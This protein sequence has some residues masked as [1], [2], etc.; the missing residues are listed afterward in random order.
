GNQRADVFEL[1]QRQ[2]LVPAPAPLFLQRKDLPI[3]RIALHEGR[4]GVSI[5]RRHRRVPEPDEL[6]FLSGFDGEHLPLPEHGTIRRRACLVPVRYPRQPFLRPWLSV[7]DDAR[8]VPWHL[9]P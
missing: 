7:S 4:R 5:P 3:P 6:E 1:R 9:L 2:L 8:S